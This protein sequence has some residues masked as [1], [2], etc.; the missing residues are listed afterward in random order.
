MPNNLTLP[1]SQRDVMLTGYVESIKA[2]TLTT[3]K[4]QA[5]SAKLVIRT[6]ENERHKV[7]FFATKLT[8]DG[9]PNP[10]FVN[11]DKELAE[12][13]TVQKFGLK[14]AD[15]VTFKKAELGTNEYVNK[16]TLKFHSR[17]EISGRFITRVPRETECEARFRVKA[18][19]DKLL[20]EVKDNEETGRLI[21]K[22]YVV[23]YQSRL[24]PLDFVI[25]GAK[26]VSYFQAN[27]NSGDTMELWGDIINRLDTFTLVEE[28]DFGVSNEKQKN[29]VVNELIATGGGIS[30]SPFNPEIM[31]MAI[32]ERK[33]MIESMIE[34][35]KNPLAANSSNPSKQQSPNDFGTEAPNTADDGYYF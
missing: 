17:M 31:K 32:R 27:V 22:T 21:L 15:K 1:E 4:G 8:K 20:P 30:E 23:G 33:T 12:V 16:Q 11:M 13:K 14:G 28:G 18:Y 6:S 35:A 26:S 2:N 24:Y 29:D 25:D 19:I 10:V 34:E 3:K 5:L 9:K 7:E